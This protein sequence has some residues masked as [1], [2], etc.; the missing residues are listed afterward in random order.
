MYLVQFESRVLSLLVVMILILDFFNEMSS[1]CAINGCF[2]PGV[3]D[4][5]DCLDGVR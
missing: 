3:L 4:I 1:F 2:S 5:S